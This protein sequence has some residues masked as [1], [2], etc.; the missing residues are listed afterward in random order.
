MFFSIGCIVG[1]ILWVI[2]WNGVGGVSLIERVRHPLGWSSLVTNVG[3]CGVYGLFGLTIIRIALPFLLAGCAISAAIWFTMLREDA[4]TGAHT[5]LLSLPIAGGTLIG[6]IVRSGRLSDRFTGR[7]SHC[8]GS[9]VIGANNGCPACQGTGHV[10]TGTG[11]GCVVMILFA[12][13]LV[14]YFAW[15]A[16]ELQRGQSGKNVSGQTDQKKQK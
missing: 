9:G 3:F 4:L 11:M 7:C 10:Q 12:C 14:G 1:L 5:I 8:H 16:I 15:Q 6:M 2:S 13:G